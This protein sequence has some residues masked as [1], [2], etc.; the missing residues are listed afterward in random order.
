ME[1]FVILHLPFV[2]LNPKVCLSNKLRN[3][4]LHNK[5]LNN[6]EY[7]KKPTNCNKLFMYIVI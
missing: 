3:L 1:A 4:D 2:P 5:T 6:V 7:I